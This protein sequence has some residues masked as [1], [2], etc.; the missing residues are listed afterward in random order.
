MGSNITVKY[1]ITNNLSGQFFTY[2]TMVD[3]P[4][5]SVLLVMLEQAEKSNKTIFG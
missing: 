3:V 2:T 1:T 4:D 5:G